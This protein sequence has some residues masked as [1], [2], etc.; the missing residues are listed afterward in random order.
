[1]AKPKVDLA[2]AVALA[3]AQGKG[4]PGSASRKGAGRE[5]LVRV[6]VHVDPELRR[7]LRHLALDEDTT[8]QA[9]AAC[10]KSPAAFE[11]PCIRPEL[12]C[13]SVTYAQYA[14]S[15]RLVRPAPGRSRCDAGFYHRL[16][17][18]EAFEV[19]LGGAPGVRRGGQ[20]STATYRRLPVG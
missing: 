6:V 14:P 11:R 10:G 19:L 18:V 7:R 8:L 2:R 12:R 5:G 20:L 16:L 4:V 3:T 13:S 15:S 9:L 1:M 17:R